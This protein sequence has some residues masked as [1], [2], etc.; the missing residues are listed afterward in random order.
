MWYQNTSNILQLCPSEL[1]SP[2]TQHNTQNTRMLCSHIYHDR[3][4]MMNMDD[5]LDTAPEKPIWIKH[6][7]SGHSGDVRNKELM[8]GLVYMVAKL[9]DPYIEESLKNDDI[10]QKKKK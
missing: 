8:R 4:V 10:L 5:N 2:P 1:P 6:W 9:L 3:E 7:T